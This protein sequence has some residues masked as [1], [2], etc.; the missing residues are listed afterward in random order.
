LLEIDRVEGFNDVPSWMARIEKARVSPGPVGAACAAWKRQPAGSCALVECAA[1]SLRGPDADAAAAW[2]A[3]CAA[4]KATSPA[5]IPAKLEAA[6]LM[7]RYWLRLKDQP[8]RCAEVAGRVWREHPTEKG[9]GGLAY[10]EARCLG[11]AGKPREAVLALDAYLARARLEGKRLAEA[12]LMVADLLVHEK[13]APERARKDLEAIIAADPKN[14]EPPYLLARLLRDTGRRAEAR[15]AV[16]KARALAP[17]KAL[18]RRFEAGLG[19]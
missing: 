16:A 15:A 18:Y 2:L 14:D 12:R 19:N 13:I 6:K 7:A 10:W 11:R 5:A 4:A 9:A 17:K 1:E 8:A 3:P